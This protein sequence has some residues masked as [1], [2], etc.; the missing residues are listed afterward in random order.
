MSLPVVSLTGQ[1]LNLTKN[2]FQ[3]G[4]AQSLIVALTMA[5]FVNQLDR[6]AR[7]TPISRLM[8]W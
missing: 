2:A 3:L 7:N 8:R 4:R 6:P 5:L 1:W